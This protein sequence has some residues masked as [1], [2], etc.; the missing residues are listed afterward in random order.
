MTG[1]ITGSATP[2]SRDYSPWALGGIVVGYVL[3]GSL[4]QSFLVKDDESALSAAMIG[5]L[6]FEPM[7]MAI[8]TALGPGSILLRAPMAVPCLFLLFVAP[9]YI[10]SVYA[11]IER[12]EFAIAIIAGFG[13]YTAATLFFLLFRRFTRLRIQHFA[14]AAGDETP[15]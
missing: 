13:I 2:Y 4:A 9:G 1:P 3:L 15:H 5:V 10:P 8:W 11:S 12:F 14:T 7:M 6:V